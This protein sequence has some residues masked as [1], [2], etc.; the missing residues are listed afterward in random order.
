MQ[1][2]IFAE[3]KKVTQ[4]E[5]VDILLRDLHFTILCEVGVRFG[6]NLHTM[7]KANPT[8]MIAVDLW[9]DDNKSRNDQGYSQA[10][11]DAQFRSIQEL[12]KEFPAIRII[13]DLSTEAAKQFPDGHFD[14]VYLDADHTYEAVRDDIKAWFPK[15]KQYGILAGH[16]YIRVNGFP[17]VNRAVDEYVRQYSLQNFFHLEMPETG[18]NSWYTVKS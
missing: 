12:Q 11:L 7:L 5:K 9:R 13:R 8:E 1:T 14:Y 6:E 17:G 15:V 18:S 4:R 2:S 16:D 10:D 3:V